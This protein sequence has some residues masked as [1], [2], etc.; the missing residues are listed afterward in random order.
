MNTLTHIFLGDDCYEVSLHGHIITR[1]T[2]YTN[3]G[4]RQELSYDD[5]PEKVQEKVLDKVEEVLRL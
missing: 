2:L 3:G 1:I 5:L 4:Q